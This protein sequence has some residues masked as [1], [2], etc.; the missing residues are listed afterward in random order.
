MLYTY[1]LYLLQSINYMNTD[2]HTRVP[3]VGINVPSQNICVS[4]PQAV[5]NLLVWF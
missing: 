1:I 4:L 3:P 5:I 2:I